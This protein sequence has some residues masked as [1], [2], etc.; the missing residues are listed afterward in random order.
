MFSDS[1]AATP[2]TDADQQN[3]AVANE[4][5]DAASKAQAFIT[6]LEKQRSEQLAE[7]DREIGDLQS[8]EASQNE[9]DD[10]AAAEMDA[11]LLTSL[12]STRQ[13]IVAEYDAMIDAARQR[14]P[15][16]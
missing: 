3:T 10:G 8:G 15:N 9:Q 1:A 5:S 13:S 11:S 16:P 7:I 12:Q 2:T 4:G 6:Q 14:I